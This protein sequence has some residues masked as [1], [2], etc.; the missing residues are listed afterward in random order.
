MLRSAVLGAEEMIFAWLCR[1]KPSC[2]V[3]SRQNILLGTKCRNKETVN[4]VLGCH[5]QF[6]RTADRN[7][8][9]IDFALPFGMLDLPHPLLPDGIHGDRV[10]RRPLDIEVQL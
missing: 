1:F 3:S 4:Y 8:K 9:F 7:M 6:H 2:G 5:G 10:I